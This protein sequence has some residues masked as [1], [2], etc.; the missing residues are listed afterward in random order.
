MRKKG[1]W[2]CKSR[3]VP[4]EV[5]MGCCR[6]SPES[7]LTRRWRKDFSLNRAAGINR[8]LLKQKSSPELFEILAWKKKEVSVASALHLAALWAAMMHLGLPGWPCLNQPPNQPKSPIK[9]HASTQITR[10]AVPT[11]LQLAGY[12]AGAI[13]SHHAAAA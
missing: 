3:V 6:Q 9:E 12:P 13:N 4:S 10:K 2:H 11:G 7:R 8:Q 1:A 5:L